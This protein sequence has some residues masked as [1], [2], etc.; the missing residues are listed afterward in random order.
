MKPGVFSRTLGLGM[1]LLLACAQRQIPATAPL[2]VE[3]QLG[4]TSERTFRLSVR[5]SRPLHRLPFTRPGDGNRLRNF[6]VLEPVGARLQSH[7]P[8]EEIVAEAP[9][10][11][12]VLEVTVHRYLP[13]KDYAPFFLLS[14]GGVLVYSGQ[15]D[16]GDQDS[17]EVRY[18]FQPLPGEFVIVPGHAIRGPVHW[19]PQG[20]GTYA[21]FS[22]VQPVEEARFIAVIDAG[23]PEWLRIEA[24]SLLPRLFD[25][26]VEALGRELPI[27]PTVLL[28]YGDAEGPGSISLK[29][30]TL[31]GWLLQ[32]DV[33]LG[34]QWR[35]PDDPKVLGVFRQSLAHEAAHLWNSRFAIPRGPDWVHEGGA[36]LLAWRALRKLGLLSPEEFFDRLSW[37]ASVCA[38]LRGS[39]ALEK[40]VVRAQ[41]TCGAIVEA[42]ATNGESPGADLVWKLLL[43]AALRVG[44]YRVDT[45]FVACDEAGAPEQA[46]NAAKALTEAGLD[47]PST[48]IKEALRAAALTVIEGVAP[49]DFTQFASDAGKAGAPWLR[50]AGTSR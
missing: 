9:F 39:S 44:S 22:P 26:Y 21:A 12:V 17:T 10:D 13:E 43:D 48:R 29:G 27:R 8:D 19:T 41:Y 15:F 37:A 38:L 40:D 11:R 28:S 45:F 18:E 6:R 35:S 34:S 30:G 46:R 47:A 24:R 50:V 2:R 16:V 7:G 49:A 25:H 31:P 32:Q 23:F 1:V 4:Q 20:D 42:V 36:D 3:A 5:L 14:G 33:Q